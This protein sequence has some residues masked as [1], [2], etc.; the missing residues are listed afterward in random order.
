M[1]AAA[2]AAAA[3]DTLEKRSFIGCAVSVLGDGN[4]LINSV[5]VYRDVHISAYCS[6]FGNLN[7]V[8]VLGIVRV[9]VS[10]VGRSV[11][12][13]YEGNVCRGC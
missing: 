4:V 1:T 3:A 7:F 10:S 5:P 13:C 6:T 12:R 8:T 9:L 2:A 11:G